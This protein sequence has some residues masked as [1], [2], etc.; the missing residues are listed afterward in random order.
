M[1]IN[2]PSV[3][4]GSCKEPFPGWCD[5]IAAAGA[6]AFPAA[7]GIVQNF[8]LHNSPVDFIPV[9]ISS[10]QI[11]VTTCHAART[12]KPEFN[13]YHN[14]SNSVNPMGAHEFMGKMGEYLKFSPF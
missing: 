9:D 13:I 7:M 2:R 5:S 6:F 1:V 14:T 12:P 11:L 3:I 4:I 8:Y 10:N